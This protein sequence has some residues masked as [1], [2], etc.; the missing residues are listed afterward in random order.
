MEKP[1][2][3]IIA[4]IPGAGIPQDDE[5]H[6]DGWYTDR[7]DAEGVFQSFRQDYPSALVH[8]VCRIK[9]DWRRPQRLSDLVARSL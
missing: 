3:G 9:S 2:Y 6:F 8:I 1:E 7:E 4:Y 5:A